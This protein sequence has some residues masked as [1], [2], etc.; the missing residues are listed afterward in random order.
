M[1]AG[2][3][4]APDRN[5]VNVIDDV[6]DKAR[7]AYDAGARELWLGQQLDFDAISLAALIGSTVPGV[8]V[9]TSVVPV[10]PRHPL[11]VAAAAQTAQAATHGNF[12]LG[13]GLGVPMLERGVFGI[14]ATN[15]VAR[16][17]EYLTV[18]RAVIDERTVNF[19]GAEITAVDPRVMPVALAGARA[20][21][22][23]VAAMGPR[24][25]QVTGELAD[26]TLPAHAGPRTIEG[27]IAP[28]ITRSAAAAGRPA[29][30][31]IPIVAVAVT[32][33]VEKVQAAAAESLAFYDQIPSYQ[34]VLAREGLSSVVELAIIGT[35]EAV[36]RGLK[37][38]FDAGATDLVLMPL[39]TE[40]AGL[41]RVCEVA[42]AL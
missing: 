36:T 35:A 39:E 14:S 29:P 20:F 38:Y 4:I 3:L 40:V 8:A 10:N 18:L 28:A 23:Y 2:V 1:A 5:A 32:D 26:G 15:T 7:V 22:L 37:N 33:D 6:L 27:F 12:R 24:A 13:L 9:G 17:R 34:K 25:L 16:L 42:A 11:I 31:I 30:R 21:P 41:Q 19:H